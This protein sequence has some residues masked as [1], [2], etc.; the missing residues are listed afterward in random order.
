MDLVEFLSPYEQ[1][2]AWLI[3][4]FHDQLYGGAGK[5][6]DWNLVPRFLVVPM[7]LSGGLTP[8]NVGEAIALF[9]PYAVDVS[10]GVELDKGIKNAA[11]IA[12]FMRAVNAADARAREEDAASLAHAEREFLKEAIPL[13]WVLHC[14]DLFT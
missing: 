2:N 7:I 1:A 3:D 5:P 12:S 14:S 4:A 6:F 13:N 9:R 8:E 10:S 11:R